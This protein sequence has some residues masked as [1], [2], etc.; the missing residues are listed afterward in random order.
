MS[1]LLIYHF[2]KKVLVDNI[3]RLMLISFSSTNSVYQNEALST[4]IP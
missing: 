2:S 4:I 1:Q 3:I